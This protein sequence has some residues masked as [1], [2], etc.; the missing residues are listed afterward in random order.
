MPTKLT[1]PNTVAVTATPQQVA[2]SPAGSTVYTLRNDSASYSIFYISDSGTYPGAKI[3]AFAGASQAVLKALGASEIRAGESIVIDNMPPSIIV[4][5][6]TGGTATLNVEA[7]QVAGPAATEATLNNLDYVVSAH[8]TATIT[9]THP[10]PHAS[11]F[12]CTLPADLVRLVLI[13]RGDVYW[14]I[15]GAAT[16]STALVAQA[17]PLSLPVTKTLADTIQV[18]AAGGGVVCDLLVCTP[19]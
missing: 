6:I 11:A 9:A 15:G 18:Y 12:N 5:C 14:K 19:R 10:I 2:F 17:S 16:A 13:P 7:G 4:V 3:A 1:V 8:Y